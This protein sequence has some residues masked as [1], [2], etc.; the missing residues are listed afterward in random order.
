MS[1]IHRE[2]KPT[3]ILFGSL[4]LI[5]HLIGF[6]W[7]PSY[8]PLISLFSLFVAFFFLQFFRNPQRPIPIVDDRLVYAPADGKVVVVE[9]AYEDE[10]LK[11]DR[12]QISIFMSPVDVHVNRS[13]IS[14]TIDYFKYHKGKYL[15]AWHPKSSILNERTTMAISN[16]K[17]NLVMRQIAGLA[18]RRIVFYPCEGDTVSQGQEVGFIKFGSRVDIFLPVSAKIL[19]K[20]GDK[21]RGAESIIA[22]IE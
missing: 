2:G 10:Y 7:Y 4:I 17:V 13:P 12:I 15:V 18:A 22:R 19:I 8:V 1:F 21:V 3:L 20:P 14:G 5:A 6:L 16:E 9:N 11:E